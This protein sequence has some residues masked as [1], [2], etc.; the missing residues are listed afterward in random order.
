MDI[1]KA[2]EQGNG[3]EAELSGRI[4]FLDEFHV[5][6][7]GDDETLVMLV[8]ITTGNW[9]P[10]NPTPQIVPEK[11]GELWENQ[12]NSFFHTELD[13]EEL[14]IVHSS[15]RNSISPS[16]IHGVN[17]WTRLFPEVKDDVEKVLKYKYIDGLDGVLETPCPY[18]YT[19][20][21]KIGSISCR[22]CESN[23]GINKKTQIVRCTHIKIPEEDKR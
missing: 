20:G 8:D 22:E 23:A 6:R 15:G 18:K 17:G 7:W 5:L 4:A 3:E 1:T 11:A 2:L 12:H 13:R 21:T 9:Q 14:M 19:S 16:I 10:Y